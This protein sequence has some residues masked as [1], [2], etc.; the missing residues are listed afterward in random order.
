METRGK[1]GKWWEGEK[2]VG[3]AETERRDGRDG[4]GKKRT[5]GEKRYRT[6]MRRDDGRRG[7]QS[8]GKRKGKKD[9][10]EKE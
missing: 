3:S 2:M 10:R 8:E 9:K 6:V 7:K 4:N 5:G 1:V